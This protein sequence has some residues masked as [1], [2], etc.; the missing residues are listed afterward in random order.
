[1]PA[2]PYINKPIVTARDAI[3]SHVRWKITLLMA[4]RMREPLSERATRS[5]QHPNECSIRQWLLSCHSLRLRRTPEYLAALDRHAA[6]HREMQTIA[7]L[8]NSGEFATAERL[9]R[10]P[11]SFETASIAVANAIMAL[12][13]ISTVKF[14]S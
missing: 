13:R 11:G 9:L 3:A 14:A 4:T 8:I 6:F 7:G 5:I 1:M 12:E 2:I 10:T